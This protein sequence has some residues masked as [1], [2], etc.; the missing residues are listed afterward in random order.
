MI[1]VKVSVIRLKASGW[2]AAQEMSMLGR[3][4]AASAVRSKAEPWNEGV[5]AYRRTVSIKN[6][7][8][9]NCRS[10]VAVNVKFTGCFK[11]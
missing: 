11:W 6:A 5:C 10:I 4:G 9:G 7:P 8:T 2:R 1:G 3:G